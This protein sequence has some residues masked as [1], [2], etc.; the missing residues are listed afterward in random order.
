MG[1]AAETPAGEAVGDGSLASM[2]Y[3]SGTTGHPKGAWRP[4]GVNI[5]N[6]LQVISIFELGQ[7]DVHLMCGPGYH[8][9]VAFFSTLHQ[10]LGATVIVQPKFA[11][12][13]AL[14]LIER[15]RVTTT[16]MA[17]PLLQRLVAPHRAS[18]KTVSS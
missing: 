8:S 6:V 7:S 5:A 10:L 13:D 12:D 1:G 9:A 4:N 14:D 16:F 2:I 15:H 11:A 17:P 3:T 18:P